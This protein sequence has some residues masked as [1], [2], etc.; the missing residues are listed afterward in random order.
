MYKWR[1]Y[2]RQTAQALDVGWKW[3]K[4]EF[5]G[6]RGER[7]LILTGKIAWYILKT[8]GI[9]LFVFIVFFK[10]LLSMASSDD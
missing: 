7:K 9:I 3:F 5:T 1:R 8:I 2:K 4:K 10:M 6:M